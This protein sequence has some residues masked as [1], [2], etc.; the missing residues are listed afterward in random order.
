MNKLFLYVQSDAHKNIVQSIFKAAKFPQSAYRL[1]V[2]QGKY[3]L[4]DIA[5]L[6]PLKK[7]DTV[8]IL[9]DLDIPSIPDAKKYIQKQYSESDVQIF[10]GVPEVESWIFADDLLVKRYAEHEHAKKILERLPLPDE[11]LHPKQ[12]AYNIFRTSDWDF[13][14]EMNLT[15]ATAR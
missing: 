9:I 3:K 14:S 4:L 6:L 2:K 11:V 5:D 12:T 10:C 15:K 1:I 7:G 8:A 13:L